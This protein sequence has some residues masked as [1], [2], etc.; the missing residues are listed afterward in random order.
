MNEL[1]E[2]TIIRDGHTYYYD[3]DYDCYYR[4][5]TRLEL[6]HMSQFGWIYVTAIL[7]AIC[8]YVQFIR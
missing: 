2:N 7:C 8:Y 3:A 5:Y 4:R 1:D 6:T